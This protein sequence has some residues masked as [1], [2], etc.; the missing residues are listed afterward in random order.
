MIFKQRDVTLNPKP[1]GFHLITKEII[2]QV[3][4]NSIN[5]GICHIFIHHTSA[6]LALNENSDRLVREDLNLFFNSLC[7]PVETQFKHTYE[8]PDDMPGH[9]NSVIIGSNISIPIKKTKLNLGTWQGIYLC[10]HRTNFPKR[11][12]TITWFGSSNKN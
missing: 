7:N 6:S 2:Q 9:I 12:I 1:Q 11:N 10:E 3:D 5:I 4:F 8:G